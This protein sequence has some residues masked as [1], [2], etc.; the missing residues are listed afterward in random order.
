MS[1]AAG[2]GRSW[3]WQFLNDTFLRACAVFTAVCALMPPDGLGVELCA[4]T[5]RAG[6][7]PARDRPLGPHARGRRRPA[8]GGQDLML[9]TCD[10]CGRRFRTK[11]CA[12]CRLSLCDGHHECPECEGDEYLITYQDTRYTNREK[13]ARAGLEYAGS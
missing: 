8:P 12:A 5:R 1:R 2:R 6:P 7:H 3:L 4:R 9:D 11:K 10:H 13:T